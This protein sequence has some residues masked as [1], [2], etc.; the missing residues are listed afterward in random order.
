MPSLSNFTPFG[1][2]HVFPMS[3]APLSVLKIYDLFSLNF[4]R[5]LWFF[6]LLFPSML[7]PT[8]LPP[9]SVLIHKPPTV[10]GPISVFLLPILIKSGTD[11]LSISSS[12]PFS[13][14]APMENTGRSATLIR[15]PA[16]L[17]LF[18]FRS[19]SSSR[20]R[21][22]EPIATNPTR[23]EGAHSEKS[24]EAA[25]HIAAP[26][27]SNKAISGISWGNLIAMST[28]SLACVGYLNYLQTVAVNAT[29]GAPLNMH[30]IMLL[31]RVPALDNERR[32][33]PTSS[34]NE[35][36]LRHCIITD[37]MSPF[38]SSR[39]QLVKP[40]V[41]EKYMDARI[42]SLDL[43]DKITMGMAGWFERRGV[44]VW[45][46]EV[47][48]TEDVEEC[49]K[50]HG[51]GRA[52]SG[53]QYD[54]GIEKEN[55]NA[56]MKIAR[57]NKTPMR[58]E[59]GR[60]SIYIGTELR[61]SR[62]K[63][64]AYHELTGEVLS[65]NALRENPNS[66]SPSYAYVASESPATAIVATAPTIQ[67]CRLYPVTIQRR[68]ITRRRRY[69]KRKRARAIASVVDGIFGRIEYSW[70]EMDLSVGSN[71]VVFCGDGER[72][73][74]V[75]MSSE[76]KGGKG[77]WEAHKNEES[78]KEFVD[79]SRIGATVNPLLPSMFF[80]ILLLLYTFLRI[81][82]RLIWK[83]GASSAIHIR[84]LQRKKM[85]KIGMYSTSR[86]SIYLTDRRRLVATKGYG[87]LKKGHLFF[88]GST[89]IHFGDGIWLESNFWNQVTRYRGA[90]HTAKNGKHYVYM[91]NCTVARTEQFT[92]PSTDTM[93]PGG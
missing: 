23:L 9:G 12:M 16:P 75:E 40:L 73:K 4:I 72:V 22:A 46:V 58:T 77:S 35:Y 83:F 17:R 81:G 71:K 7:F 15:L 88:N 36:H 43:A 60:K 64:T 56:R 8:V 92:K 31:P 28:T 59:Q 52:E 61:I 20:L 66:I 67:S 91:V 78:D 68:Y 10:N 13:P 30:I 39:T 57:T 84:I 79:R 51:K 65:Q 48:G 50:V 49:G 25:N 74:K 76:V 44:G 42:Q 55:V 34:V 62:V 38:Q 32:G 3:L 11:L 89:P 14:P 19:F 86:G 26:Y 93:E 33:S 21:L 63:R 24:A 82:L 45:D 87:K 53:K 54:G 80:S 18:Y 2:A 5:V 47:V 29:A 27:Q 90:T 41:E 1:F 70:T 85:N 6:G 69:V 37:R